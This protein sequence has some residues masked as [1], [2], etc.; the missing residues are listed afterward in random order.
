MATERDRIEFPCDYR[1][2]V[3]GDRHDSFRD[4]VVEI[5]RGHAPD[6]EEL[7]VSVQDSRGGKYCSVRVTIVATGEA[8]LKALHAALLAEPAIRMVL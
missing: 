4:T 3:I 1:I 6:L 7:S 2:H 8:Q 5:V